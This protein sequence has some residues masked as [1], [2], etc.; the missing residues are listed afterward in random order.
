MSKV[1]SSDISLK[2]GL[3]AFAYE[4]GKYHPTGE[5]VGEVP[6]CPC[7]ICVRMAM[8]PTEFL[9]KLSD[10]IVAKLEYM[11]GCDQKNLQNVLSRC[12]PTSCL[13]PYHGEMGDYLPCDCCQSFHD[14]FLR[15][16]MKGTR[17]QLR[18]IDDLLQGRTVTSIPP[19]E[20]LM[21]TDMAGALIQILYHGTPDF[22]EH[23]RSL[24]N[25]NQTHPCECDGCCFDDEQNDLIIAI[26]NYVCL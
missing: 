10:S 24:I 22:R 13:D 11:N 4:I 9:K 17:E 6:G 21:E 23:I 18:Q 12:P 8:S 26:R 7:P 5:N 25:D 14:I 19:L 16:L 1:L 15:D 20:E 3:A 2:T